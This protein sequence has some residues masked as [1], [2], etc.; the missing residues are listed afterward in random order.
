MPG[1]DV[2]T[3]IKKTLRHLTYA[4]V[5]LCIVTTVVDIYF[6]QDGRSKTA[7][8]QS[9]RKDSILRSCIDQNTRHDLTIRFL[10]EQ[11]GKLPT[12]QKIEAQVQRKVTILFINALA[13]HRNCDLLVL[14]SVGGG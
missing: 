6:W 8:I 4:V 14:R 13:P 12:K 7:D 3:S 9:E 1:S 5:V 11:I 10:D 2:A